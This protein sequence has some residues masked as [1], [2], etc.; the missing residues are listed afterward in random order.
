VKTL[1]IASEPHPSGLV[2]RIAGEAGVDN[3]ESLADG[4]MKFCAQKPK[5]V[6]FDLSGLDFIASMGMGVLMAFRQE[7]ARSGGIVRVA[8]AQPMV[9]DAFKRAC[10]NALF[11]T[12][13]SVDEALAK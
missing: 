11:N 8:A 6:V 2:I 9:L 3:V 10:L 13:A 7:L 4:L 12:C 5:L 1:T